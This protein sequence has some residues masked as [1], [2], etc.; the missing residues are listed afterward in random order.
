MGRSTTDENTMNAG[1]TKIM[2]ARLSLKTFS[3]LSTPAAKSSAFFYEGAWVFY[4]LS[5]TK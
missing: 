4:T 2:M 1:S 5:P 3:T